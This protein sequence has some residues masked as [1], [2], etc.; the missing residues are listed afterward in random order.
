[1]VKRLQENEDRATEALFDALERTGLRSVKHELGTFSLNDL[2]WPSI[3]DAEAAR[4][5]AQA[6]MPELITLNN[7][8]L[9]VV[10][11]DYLKGERDNLPAGVDFR[12]SRKIGWRSRPGEPG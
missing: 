3:T 10:V 2:A 4:K 7:A 9:A 5:W 1:V 6:E 8:R 12:T 11:R